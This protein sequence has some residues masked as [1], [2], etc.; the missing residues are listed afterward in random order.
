MSTMQN[1]ENN[2]Q[3]NAAAQTDQQKEQERKDTLA[4]QQK[5]QQDNKDAPKNRSRSNRGAHSGAARYAQPHAAGGASRHLLVSSA[6]PGAREDRSADHA[7]AASRAAHDAPSLPA[8]AVHHPAVFGR[9]TQPAG[10]GSAG[11]VTPAPG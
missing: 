1:N 5:Q 10:R 7:V 9:A 4:K 11:P 3:K 8:P 2:V 6:T